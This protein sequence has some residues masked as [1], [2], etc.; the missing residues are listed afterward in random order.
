MKKGTCVTGTITDS[1]FPGK[2]RVHVEPG[3]NENFMPFDCVVKGGIEGQKVTVRIKKKREGSCTGTLLNVYKRSEIETE[4]VS[5]PNFG[6]C[7]G[8]AY[9]S[10]PVKKQ[11]EMKKKWIRKLFCD[12]ITKETNG[13]KDFDDIYEGIFESPETR[14]YRNKMEFSFGDEYKGGPI[15]LGLHKKHGMFDILDADRCELIHPDMQKITRIARE[16]AS[17]KNIPFYNKVSHEGVL[18]FLLM[19]RS[20]TTG[21]L[22]VA[23][24]TSSQGTD[25]YSELCERFLNTELSG[26]LAGVIHV[27]TD[28]F[29]DTVSCDSMNILYG[30]DFFYEELLE[31]KF[32]VSL[33]SFFQTNTA[34]A[35]VLYTKVREYVKDSADGRVVYDLYSGTG[36]IAQIM[37]PAAQKVIGVEIVKDAVDAAVL[38][39]GINGLDNCSFIAGDVLKVLD[40]IEEKPGFI[41]LDPPR[42]GIHPKAL[43][44]IASYGVENIV[45]ISCKPTSLAK[46]IQVFFE[47]GYRAERMCSV[48]MFPNTVHVETVV[49]LGKR[50]PDSYV[51]LSLNMEDYYKIKDQ[52]KAEGEKR[53]DKM[54]KNNKKPDMDAK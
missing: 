42:E 43:K 37:A 12:V 22:L 24:V 20:H 15:T 16:Y 9:L 46:D 14:G 13:G 23:I 34:G 18:R 30:R 19:R 31:L 1:A 40:D 47:N 11:L 33:F 27:I 52:E 32:K 7:G 10:V 45:Y 5:C 49:L 39:A 29:G 6:T 2:S 51:K 17:E 48:D 41:M 50:K 4:K 21:E 28:N 38:N 53:K 8:C 3:E 54:S 35:E 44:K 25:D 36:T 26:S